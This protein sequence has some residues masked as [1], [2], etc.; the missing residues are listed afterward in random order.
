LTFSC[1]TRWQKV[2]WRASS[3]R[4]GVV[5][6]ERPRR[7]CHTGLAFFKN[8]ELPSLIPQRE[9]TYSASRSAP[10]SAASTLR[11]SCQVVITARL[12]HIAGNTYAHPVSTQQAIGTI[13]IYVYKYKLYTHLPRFTGLS[14]RPCTTSAVRT[15]YNAEVAEM[16]FTMTCS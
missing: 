16:S 8:R 10:G 2:I 7:T 3:R 5:T 15:R 13:H 11:S 4:R 14:Q 12:T 1:V 9:A 6:E